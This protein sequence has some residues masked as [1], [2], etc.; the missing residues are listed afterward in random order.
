MSKKQFSISELRSLTPER[1]V[2]KINYEDY[3]LLDSLSGEDLRKEMTTVGEV[4]HSLIS[5]FYAFLGSGGDEKT[6][7]KRGKKA[8]KRLVLMLR[9]VG[10]VKYKKSDFRKYRTDHGLVLGFNHPS[11]GEIG[12]LMI[13]KTE[14]FPEKTA[15]FPVNLP[16]YEALAKDFDRIKGLGFELTPTIT[17]TTWKRLGLKEGSE[18]YAAGDELR[19]NLKDLY[20][21]KSLKT[22]KNG[23]LI[24]V[25]PSAT[26][27]A[28]VFASKEVYE[29]KAPIIPT[30][31]ILALSIFKDPEIECDFLPLGVVPPENYSRSLNIF[32]TYELR[33]GEP[34]G[35]SYIRKKYFAE[36]KLPQKL[37]G[38]DYDFHQRLAKTLPKN[39]WF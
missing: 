26:R 34:M 16:W 7:M 24:F 20:T 19:H 21:E 17:P 32:K 39:M 12:R 30:M 29:K 33:A 31:S 13:M 23:G 2:Q 25:A 10:P 38:F 27:Q 1:I 6:A 14:I 11:L 28:T 36:T 8:K 37:E 35:S 15:L 5:Y 22:I 9:K 4:C 18:L 3:S